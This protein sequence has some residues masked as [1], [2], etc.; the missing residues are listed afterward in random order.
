VS[1]AIK[2]EKLLDAHI[3]GLILK[4]EYMLKKQKIF[5]QKIELSDKLR[6]FEQ[7]G[8]FWLEPMRF[9]ILDSKQAGIIA[10]GENFEDKKNFLKK[11]G[12]NPLLAQYNGFVSHHDIQKPI[13]ETVKAIRLLK[14][15]GFRILI[16]STRGDEFIKKYCEDF[17]IPVDFINHNPEMEGENPG[18]PVAY[19]YIDDSVIRYTGQPAE[20]LVSEVEN[21]KAYWKR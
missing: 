15:K 12:S 11:I 14:E 2:I 21:F 9:F 16:H 7:K 10:S 6:D 3:D 4:D 19:V 8:N 13:V 18:K 20:T 1:D 5:N 17:S